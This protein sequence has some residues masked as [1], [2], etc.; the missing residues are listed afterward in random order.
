[1]PTTKQHSLLHPHGTAIVIDP[2]ESFEI[3]TD[4]LRCVHCQRIMMY[5]K[6]SGKHLGFCAKCNGAT[7][8]APACT[9]ECRHWEKALELVEA[10]KIESF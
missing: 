6:G 2:A 4:C 1:M 8:D 3:H 5:R 10:G 7:C 9:S